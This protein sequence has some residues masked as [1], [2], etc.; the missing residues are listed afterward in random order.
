MSTP[1]R[2]NKRRPN[3]LGDAETK[4]RHQIQFAKGIEHPRTT[5]RTVLQGKRVFLATGIDK[6]V[7][8]F[9]WEART[10]DS[11]DCERHRALYA[12]DYPTHPKTCE[13]HRALYVK[14]RLRTIEPNPGPMKRGKK[15]WSPEKRKED[16]TR[17]RER[18][19]RLTRE[20]LASVYDQAKETDIVTWNLQRVSMNEKNR[21]RLREVVNYCII[22]RWKIVLISEVTAADTGMIWFGEGRNG[23]VVIHST[24]SAILLTGEWRQAWVKE[25]MQRGV[26]DRATMV[27][28]G[29]IRMISCYQPTT[30]HTE[31]E[32]EKYRWELEEFVKSTRSNEWLIIGGDH[33][34][35]VGKNE[36]GNYVR[37]TCGYHGLGK[38]NDAGRS[39]LRWC[40]LHGLAWCDSFYRIE[41]RGT[42]QNQMNG[43]WHELDGFIVRKA[44]RNR[45]VNEIK[46]LKEDNFSDHRPKIIRIK[47]EKPKYIPPKRKAR[48]NVEKL[49]QP[50]TLRA[51]REETKR[52]LDELEGEVTWSKMNRLLSS[53]AMKVCGKQPKNVD[54]PWMQGHEDEIREMRERLSGQIAESKEILAADRARSPRYIQARENVQ[55]T[56]RQY[57]RMKRT[58]ERCYWEEMIEAARDAQERNDIGAMYKI[59]RKLGQR[60]T[61]AARASEHFSTE[62]YKAH[63]EKVSAERYER[64]VD[65]IQQLMGDIE[66]TELNA[67]QQRACRD[68]A[69]DFSQKDVMEAIKAVKDSAP[70]ADGVRISFIRLADKTVQREIVALVQELQHTPP[71]EWQQCIKVGQVVPLFK[72]GSRKD[73]NNY[74]GVCLLIM[75]SRILAKIMSWR[76]RTWSERMG[77]MD[78]NQQAITL[79]RR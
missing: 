43:K 19:H 18:R 70:G 32:I 38:T 71:L 10:G 1:S 11:V 3:L 22:K 46:V 14:F 45:L 21:K 4:R 8:L 6:P 68:L 36:G 17:Q 65:E 35:V 16:R 30:E 37:G 41:Q 53:A 63:F 27:Q 76:L 79:R 67:D 72:K 33:N 26:G 34:S 52:L 61:K 39:L 9:Q 60:D 25:G 15:E 69:R 2:G 51:Y 42:W 48:V 7:Y 57:Q 31:E 75:A 12:R 66:E 47:L 54:M 20:K 59:L 74:R 24:K 23:A 50:E 78:D 44:Q 58:W 77:L 56:R 5:K 49:K 40:E 28:I 62:E 29:G 55:I 73:L 13:R 64:P